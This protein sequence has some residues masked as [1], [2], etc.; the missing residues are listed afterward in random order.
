MQ[1][2]LIGLMQPYAQLWEAAQTPDAMGTMARNYL[3]TLAERF[4][5]PQD[6]HPDELE[7]QTKE[8]MEEAEREQEETQEKGMKE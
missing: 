3:K 1:Q 5:L 8:R 4:D 2:N 7:I 6:L